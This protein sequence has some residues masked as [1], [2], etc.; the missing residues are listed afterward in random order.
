MDTL[1]LGGHPRRPRSLLAV[2]RRDWG[3]HL[4]P[5]LWGA[6]WTPADPRPLALLDLAP[7]LTA[8]PTP[9]LPAHTWVGSPQGHVTTADLGLQP[10]FLGPS[11]PQPPAGTVLAVS[12]HPLHRC[13]KLR[14]ST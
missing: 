12:T 11:C 8:G 10:V 5:A 4:H 14:A 3:L 2:L 13:R 6:R 1:S 7:C 9:F